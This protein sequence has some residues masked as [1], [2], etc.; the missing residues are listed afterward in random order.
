MASESSI[1][2]DPSKKQSPLRDVAQGADL[3]E[4]LPPAKSSQTYRPQQT[5]S[6]S[7]ESNASLFFVGTATTILEWEG[8][9][10]M[11]DPNFLHAGDHVH[12]GPGVRGTRKTNPAVDLHDLPHID[13]VL[14]SHYHADHFDQEVEASLRR[15]LPI[16]TTPHAHKHLTHKGH[17]EAFTAVHPLDA[18]ESMFVNVTSSSTSTRRPHLRVTG[19]PGKHVGDGLLAKANDILGA[20]PPTNGW[21]LELG[22]ISCDQSTNLECGHR[23]Y[24]SGDTLYVSELEKIPEL[25]THAG[26]PI[27]LM[28]I[29]LGGTTVPGPHMP[30]VM[31]TMDAE[32]GVKLVKL[33]K[34]EV[35]VPIHYDDYDVFLS[36]LSDFKDAIT[37]AGLSDKVIYLDRGDEFK[38]HVK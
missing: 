33:V 34:P 14:L 36:P 26:K 23:I 17:G 6:E 24:I 15:D 10:L 18:W 7:A 35:T 9:R 28:L 30:L 11:T 27:D 1:T 37:K 4:Q 31:V 25:Y 19:T 16:I 22:Y 29:H 5:S 21:M 20:I 8:L 38:F 32:Q 13:L 2:V 3:K 12:L